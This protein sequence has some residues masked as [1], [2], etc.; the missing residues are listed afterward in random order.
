MFGKCRIKLELLL[1]CP[2]V[3]L[4]AFAPLIKIIGSAGTALYS[5]I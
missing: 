1:L 5:L 2:P 3:R 4:L